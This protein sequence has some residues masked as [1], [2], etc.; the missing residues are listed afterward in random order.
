[1]TRYVV[2]GVDGS[3]ASRVALRWAA[4]EA[5][6]REA[7]L[8]VVTAV[9]GQRAAQRGT[10]GAAVDRSVLGRSVRRAV[11][12]VV[13]VHPGLEV[14]AQEIAG[15]PEAVLHDE[16]RG[17][18][19]VV[20]GT[21]G[22]GGFAGLR[23]GSVALGV[24]AGGQ[25]AVGLVPADSVVEARDHEVVVGVDGHHPDEEA[26]GLAFDAAQRREARL[27][28]VHAWRLPAPFD[29]GLLAPVEEDRAEWEDEEVQ[30]LGDALRA[31]REKHPAVGLLP[32][33]RLFG[34][35]DAL[36]RASGGADLLVV[37]RGQARTARGLGGVAHAVAHH[38]RCPLIL[39]PRH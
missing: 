18:E 5:V 26:L 28:A 8:R 23:L 2:A 22:A 35:A 25:C 34:P 19:L 36:V 39:A 27:R 7:A 21:R 1:M 33:V 14:A 11:A 29:D 9:P 16:G 3:R 10:S 6:A 30:L 20:V 15:V 12:D 32:D 31:W 37:G 38:T 24:A 13:R 4:A 17:A